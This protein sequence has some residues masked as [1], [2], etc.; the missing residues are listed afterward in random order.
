MRPKTA[1]SLTQQA[2]GRLQAGTCTKGSCGRRGAAAGKPVPWQ[3]CSSPHLQVLLLHVRGVQLVQH[4]LLD[5][6]PDGRRVAAQLL[7]KHA[8][9]ALPA[10]SSPVTARSTDSAWYAAT[11]RAGMT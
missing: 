11:A 10:A 2:H 6:P 1:K 5:R 7:R 4:R 9:G 8:R 3:A